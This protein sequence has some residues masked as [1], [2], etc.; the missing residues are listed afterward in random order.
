MGLPDGVAAPLGLIV[1]DCDADAAWLRV[2][3]ADCDEVS[4]EVPVAVNEGVNDGVDDEDGLR[5][6][7]PEPVAVEVPDLVIVLDEVSDGVA[8]CVDVREDVKERDCDWLGVPVRLAVWVTVA[9]RVWD[10]DCVP[11]RVAEAV[12]VR[13]AEGVTVALGVATCEIDRVPEPLPLPPCEGEFVLLGEDDELDVMLTEGL[14]VPDG[15]RVGDALMVSD[16]E[17]LGDAVGAGLGVVEPL[18]ERVALRVDVGLG[19]LAPLGDP[20]RVAV[21]VPVPT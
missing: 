1:D 10:L 3:V 15:D 16:G 18:G 13:A 11:E 21:W 20:E 8:R 14:P 4:A 12:G 19:V 6:A 17:L 9:D 5:A 7:E 2:V